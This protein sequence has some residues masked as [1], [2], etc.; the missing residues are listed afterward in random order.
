MVATTTI[1]KFWDHVTIVDIK[2]VK[3]VSFIHVDDF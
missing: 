3:K 1:N 2:A